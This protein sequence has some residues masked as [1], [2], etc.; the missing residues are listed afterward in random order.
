V[1]E[2]D[3]DHGERGVRQERGIL[4]L[5]A[6]LIL[7]IIA[8]LVLGLFQVAAI[9]RDLLVL[10]EAARAGVRAA[11]TSSGTDAARRAAERSAPEL[12]GLRVTVTPTARR[13]GDVVQVEVR[14][15]RRIGP[16]E[17]EVRARAVAQVE[18][19]VG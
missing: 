12:S 7:P 1:P 6:V 4:S 2:T 17:H 5:E 10:H 13:A 11:A 16:V 9:G 8:L 14:A 18:P 15:V 3:V 19:V